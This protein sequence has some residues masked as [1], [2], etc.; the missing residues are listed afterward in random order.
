MPGLES[1]GAPPPTPPYSHPDSIQC[2]LVEGDIPA[3][4]ARD[5]EVDEKITT[6]AGL[7]N[8]H[9]HVE[10]REV[11][12]NFNT[13]KT[14][15]FGTAFSAAPTIAIAMLK[16]SE[17]GKPLQVT[18]R[19]TTGCFLRNWVSIYDVVGMVIAMETT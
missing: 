7:P 17:V 14:L 11:T 3:T 18:S 15:T 5:T 8:A 2:T 6:H 4:I 16:T 19:S 10:A 9:R 13:A 12:E 1:K